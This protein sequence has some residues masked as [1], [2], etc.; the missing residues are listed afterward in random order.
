MLLDRE[1]KS[2]S[3][4]ARSDRVVRNTPVRPPPRG[5]KVCVD[6]R[7]SDASSESRPH[8]RPT[9]SFDSTMYL[10]ESSTCGKTPENRTANNGMKVTRLTSIGSPRWDNFPSLTLFQCKWVG[11]YLMPTVRCTPNFSSLGDRARW[12]KSVCRD[13]VRQHSSFDRWLRSPRLASHK[14]RALVRDRK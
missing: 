11:A 12:Q 14:G 6:P 7:H 2:H 5:R 9:I 10:A 1:E 8:R 4:P 13:P 3:R